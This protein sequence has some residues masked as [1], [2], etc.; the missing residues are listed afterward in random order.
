MLA[1]E[2]PAGLKCLGLGPCSIELLPPIL[3][4][5]RKH[6]LKKK[7]PFP[8]R[9][10]LCNFDL[11]KQPISGVDPVQNKQRV[12]APKP[13]ST[14][15]FSQQFSRQFLKPSHYTSALAS[16][17]ISP[18][19]SF[20]CRIISVCAAPEGI[21]GKQLASLATRQSTITGPL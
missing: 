12:L 4:G 14:F 18:E 21:I 10:L 16:S 19:T 6:R 1:E 8:I 17:S 3:I 9:H 15:G 5:E 13:A 7:C 11:G 2:F 20:A